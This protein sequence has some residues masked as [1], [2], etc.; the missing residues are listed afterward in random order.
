MAEAKSRPVPA[1]RKMN[2]DTSTKTRLVQ[3]F[4]GFNSSSVSEEQVE[5][6]RQCIDVIKPRSARYEYIPFHMI[7]HWNREKRDY[8]EVIAG[9]CDHLL[10]YA[11][12][13]LKTSKWPRVW[14]TI[15]TNKHKFHVHV[16][17]GMIGARD[18]LEKMGYSETLPTAIKFPDHAKEPDREKVRVIAAE[19][20]MGKLEAQGLLKDRA[21]PFYSGAG[22]YE[23]AKP[24][25][26]LIASCGRDYR[27]NIYKGYEGESPYKAV[28]PPVGNVPYDIP[29]KPTTRSTTS[30]YCSGAMHFIPSTTTST[31][32]Y[33]KTSRRS[34]LPP[35]TAKTFRQFLSPSGSSKSDEKFSTW[36]ENS[37]PQELPAAKSARIYCNLEELRR[38][39]Q[40]VITDPLME[41]GTSKS[42]PHEQQSPYFQMKL[43]ES[44][45]DSEIPFVYTGKKTEV[46]WNEVGISLFFPAAECDKD[47]K[48]T[49][50]AVNDDYILPSEN[51]DMPLASA[52]YQI[53]AS[54]A[55]PAP[56]RIR[57]AHCAV[58]K[59]DNTLRF[60]TAHG[61]SPHNFKPVPSGSGVFPHGEFY[62]ELE[63]REFSFFTI[64]Q[65]IRDWSM[66]FA[67]HVF[68]CRDGSADFVVTKDI[69]EQR[70]AVKNK[71]QRETEVV[72]FTMV[73]SFLTEA[74][75]LTIPDSQSDDGW[76]IK[77]VVEPP[78][79]SMD[80]IHAYKTGNTIPS[81]KMMV[82]WEREG[83][84]REETVN[85]GVL[86]GDFDSFNLPCKHSPSSLIPP[87]SSP[88]PSGVKPRLS[89]LKS[90]LRPLAWSEIKDMALFLG[91]E[92]ATLQNIE[93]QYFEP[94]QRLTDTLNAWLVSDCRASWKK[95][96][97]SLK[98]I[99][100]NVLARTI[101]LS[102]ILESR[103]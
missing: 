74:I 31:E 23:S 79:L 75:T 69:P 47:I 15:K 46:H 19:L 29:E 25:A 71:Y 55:L 80:K 68:R 102:W 1:R 50:K 58:V 103:D 76:S 18:I 65:N 13:L 94:S 52:V 92:Y 8:L 2:V 59:R 7:L 83:P 90:E 85:I 24:S 61:E 34:K 48:F 3:S 4:V 82:K 77:P 60:M 26:G 12:D 98:A 70:N 45:L 53:S 33:T 22:S 86:G 72:E 57:M 28:L 67:V 9:S 20:L 44:S 6:A 32:I 38:E 81:I 88:L 17:D 78:R 89:D 21:I 5:L 51:K 40:D 62:G 27:E 101:E 10:N 84:P 11:I 93:Q 16:T 87:P 95:I 54:D 64:L 41:S 97:K 30:D 56:V 49:I 39:N 36:S 42:L 66:R 99:R 63:L 73:C 91:L 14:R 43:L 35:A 37:L 100:Q 96:V